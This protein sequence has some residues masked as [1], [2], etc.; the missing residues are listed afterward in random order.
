MELYQ[1]IL[2]REN[3]RKKAKELEAWVLSQESNSKEHR[4]HP[5]MK[6]NNLAL[7]LAIRQVLKDA[8]DKYAELDEKIQE[9]T[10]GMTLESDMSSTGIDSDASKDAPETSQE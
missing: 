5:L 6:P 7:S 4:N 3:Y 1:A 8:W 2:K 10:K 9:A